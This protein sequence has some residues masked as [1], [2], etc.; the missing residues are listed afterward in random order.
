MHW[1]NHIRNDYNGI[2]PKP[3]QNDDQGGKYCFPV[4]TP[5][6]CSR[7]CY[8]GCVQ[9]QRC[10]SRSSS[11]FLDF[12]RKSLEKSAAR[13]M[14]NWLLSI[15]NKIWSEDI[16]ES[17]IGTKTLFVDPPLSKCCRDSKTSQDYRLRFCYIVFVLSPDNSLKKYPAQIPTQI[18]LARYC[19]NLELEVR[20][21]LIDI[22][23]PKT[24][25]WWS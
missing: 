24:V 3:C 13:L 5:I 23:F 20:T 9:F 11:R 1:S 7:L 16:V 12:Q 22:D 4:R 8:H 17:G 21:I 18:V 2:W 6:L 19:D 14:N 10:L 25:S 15:T